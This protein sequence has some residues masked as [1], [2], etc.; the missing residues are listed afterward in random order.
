[1]QAL[2]FTYL[3][4]ALKLY[5]AFL[6]S[7]QFHKTNQEQKLT[8]LTL[9]SVG[10]CSY[11]LIRLGSPEPQKADCRRKFHAFFVSTSNLILWNWDESEN[12]KN[13][14]GEKLNYKNVYL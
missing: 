13:R 5:L 10:F 9:Y 12:P 7:G 1:M 2:Q 4:K 3:G 8:T 14:V 6:K 11:N